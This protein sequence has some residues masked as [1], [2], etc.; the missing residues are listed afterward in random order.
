MTR[1][2]KKCDIRCNIFYIF[3]LCC[4]HIVVSCCVVLRVV[5]RAAQLPSSCMPYRIV[6][7]LGLVCDCVVVCYV[8]LCYVMLCYVMLGMY[9]LYCTV[10]S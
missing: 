9:A 1:N 3:C 7:C 5:L 8:M 2:D 4:P 6:C 10:V